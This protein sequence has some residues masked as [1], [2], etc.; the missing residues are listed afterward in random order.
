MLIMYVYNYFLAGQTTSTATIAS[1]QRKL[2]G[3]RKETYNVH[4]KVCV[5]V[6]KE[7]NITA[8]VSKIKN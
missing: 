8:E 5:F 1:E 3:Q 7:C 2:L 4:H 6:I